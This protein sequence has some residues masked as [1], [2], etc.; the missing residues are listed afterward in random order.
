MTV[1]DRLIAPG[2]TRAEITLGYCA[3]AGGAAAAGAL[4]WQAGQMWLVVVV[5]ALVGFDMFGGAVVNATASATRWYHRQGRPAHGHLLFVVVHIQPFVLALAVPGYG[6]TAAAVTYG[7]ALVSAVAVIRS[8][9]AIRTPVAFVAV[10]AGILV[11]T[12][13][14][15][16]PPFLMWFAPVLLIKLL[17]GHLLPHPVR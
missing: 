5:T 6:W 11:T 8:P 15:T 7:L 3:G 12:T 10:V 14:V 4:A 16:V 1:T 9:W 2:A 13:L 17:L